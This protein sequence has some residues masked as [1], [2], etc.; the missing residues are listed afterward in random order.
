MR[1]PSC[2]LPAPSA[3]WGTWRGAAATWSGRVS[4]LLGPW[5]VLSSP[6]GLR[7]CPTVHLASGCR[8]R[9]ISVAE[10]SFFSFYRCCSASVGLSNDHSVWSFL[11]F[12]ALDVRVCMS[13]VRIAVCYSAS[14]VLLKQSVSGFPVADP[15]VVSALKAPM[16]SAED[17]QS[18]C[19]LLLSSCTH[20]HAVF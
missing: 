15:V 4:A 7:T 17:P 9:K 3:C 2:L 10:D 11:L 5:R 19:L 12:A 1:R 8:C 20:L 6:V 14:K 13:S 18:F 16:P